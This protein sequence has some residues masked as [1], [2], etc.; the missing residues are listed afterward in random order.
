MA[1]H[2]LKQ[3]GR[4]FIP[5]DDADALTGQL[6]YFTE[7][8]AIAAVVGAVAIVALRALGAFGGFRTRGAFAALGG[9]GTPGALAAFRL[10]CGAG[11][12]NHQR[13]HVLS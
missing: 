5:G 3:T 2:E 11:R 7:L 10:V 6:R 4:R 9:F 8:V 12:R 13:Y 1:Q